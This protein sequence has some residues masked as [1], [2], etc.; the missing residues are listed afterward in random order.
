MTTA[1][2]TAAGIWV[3]PVGTSTYVV[4][5]EICGNVKWDTVVVRESPLGIEDL[6]FNSQRLTLW[7]QPAKEEVKLQLDSYNGNSEM[8]LFNNLG[9]VVRREE[10]VFKELKAVV[11]VGDLE[12]G[13]YFIELKNGKGYSVRSKLVL[14]R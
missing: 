1:L 4:R 5:Q 7:P 11:R 3:T 14:E 12:E 13:V 9:M 2:D 8:F 10:I 6:K